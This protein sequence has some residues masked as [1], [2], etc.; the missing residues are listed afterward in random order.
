[1]LVATWCLQ[2]VPAI[3]RQPNG[4]FLRYPC[5]VLL[6]ARYPFNSVNLYSRIVT[7]TSCIWFLRS[8]SYRPCNHRFSMDD[9]VLTS[10]CFTEFEYVGRQILY[11]LIA[12]PVLN[13]HQ[14]GFQLPDELYSYSLLTSISIRDGVF[15]WH[16]L[17]NQF[18]LKSCRDR[19]SGKNNYSKFA[20]IVKSA[21]TLPPKTARESS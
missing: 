7:L 5:P 13:S 19:L 15:I 20:R 14:M 11:F 12:G 10:S 3:W 21:S 9:S 6:L 4:H 8:W 1:M 2:H 16:V 17:G 18:R